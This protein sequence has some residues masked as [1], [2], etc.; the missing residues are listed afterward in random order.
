MFCMVAFNDGSP[1]V[2]EAFFMINYNLFT[3]LY[4]QH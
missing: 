3:F 4:L 2:V 1:L